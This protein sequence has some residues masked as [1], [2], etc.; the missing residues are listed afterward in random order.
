MR[1]YFEPRRPALVLA[2]GEGSVRVARRVLENE[3]RVP[4]I[5]LL[6]LL[7][8][9]QLLPSPTRPSPT[10]SVV[11]SPRCAVSALSTTASESRARKTRPDSARSAPRS[12][13]RPTLPATSSSMT[14]CRPL[15]RPSAPAFPTTGRT[16]RAGGTGRLRPTLSSR[17][18]TEHLS[19]EPCAGRRTGTPRPRIVATR[20]S[21]CGCEGTS[22][23]WI[24]S[25]CRQQPTYCASLALGGV[26]RDRRMDRRRGSRS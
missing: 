15:H 21:M 1:L 3:Q 24:R 22:S 17:P 7:I 6:T 26:A 12:Q 9:V 2:K 19:R 8:P 16:R 4:V 11:D 25:R 23:A 18:P 20:T 10:R 13:L 14:V 5:Q